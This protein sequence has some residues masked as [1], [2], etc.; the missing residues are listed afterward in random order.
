VRVRWI[1]A[2]DLQFNSAGLQTLHGLRGG[3]DHVDAITYVDLNYKYTFDDLIG[4]GSTTVEVG[5]NNVF[6]EYPDPF[7]NLGGI[8][9]FVHDVRGRMWYLRLNQTL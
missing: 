9:T 7:F 8:E 2:F 4:D 5:A 1:D 3:E 6:D